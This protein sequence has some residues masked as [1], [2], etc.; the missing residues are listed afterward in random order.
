MKKIKSKNYDVNLNIDYTDDDIVDK[1]DRFGRQYLPYAIVKDWIQRMGIRD[2]DHLRAYRDLYK[3]PLGIPRVPHYVYKD[4]YEGKAL[5]YTPGLPSIMPYPLAVLHVRELGIKTVK[6]YRQYHRE[7]IF[8]HNKKPWQKRK[9][10]GNRMRLPAHP[11]GCP[12]WKKFWVSWNQFLGSNNKQ[13]FQKKH[14]LPFNEAVSYV[15]YLGIKTIEQWEEYTRTEDFPDFLP[16]T[17]E[18]YYPADEWKGYRVW[19]NKDVVETIKHRKSNPGVWALIQDMDETDL[20]MYKWMRYTVGIEH[21]KLQSV[22]EQFKIIKC[23]EYESELLH[24]VDNILKRNT[25]Y[26]KNNELCVPNIHQLC[27]DLDMKLLIIR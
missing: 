16:K 4:Q 23:Y 20:R 13:G 3:V 8:P 24:E 25:T 21:V 19:L 18:L 6:Q 2:I 14:C 17:P 10:F 15:A 11:L 1:C 22:N 26:Y 7:H 27:F 12:S 9:N 5:F